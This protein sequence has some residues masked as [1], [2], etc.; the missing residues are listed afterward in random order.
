VGKW[1]IACVRTVDELWV[2]NHPSAKYAVQPA[3]LVVDKN[4]LLNLTYEDISRLSIRLF[5]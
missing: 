1:P 2:T 5:R 4:F 3:F